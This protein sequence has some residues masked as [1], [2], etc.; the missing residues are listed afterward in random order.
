[1]IR[2][3]FLLFLCHAAL[4][5]PGIGIV[6]DSHGN[7]FYT[8]LAQVWKITSDG[9][10]SIAVPRVHTHQLYLDANDNLYGEHLWYNGER[11]NTWGH[12]VWMYSATGEFKKI[13]A[14]REGFL[15]DFSFV[16]DHAGNGYRA[17]RDHE[18]QT[19]YRQPAR[20]NDVRHTQECFRKIGWLTITRKDELAFMHDH[21]ELRLMDKSGTSRKIGSIAAKGTMGIWDDVAGNLY[22]ATYDDRTVRQFIPEG[23]VIDVYQ[24]TW[25][26]SPTGGLVTDTGDLWLLETNRLN[27]VRVERI[28]KNGK[29][30]TF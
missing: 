17:D 28:S 22:T 4:A 26:W 30:T 8:D 29:A 13:T 6:M 24:T 1:M 5:H 18:C 23:R 16:H 14:D 3:L 11:L 12:Y 10:K 20:G 19:I 25:P 21:H 15:E 2:V 7:V 27:Q 9:R